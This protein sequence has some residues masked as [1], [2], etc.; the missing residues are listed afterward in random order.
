PARAHVVARGVRRGRG[1][2]RRLLHPRSFRRP[3]LLGLPSPR[4]RRRGPPRRPDRG[5]QGADLHRTEA[6]Y[7][8]PGLDRGEG[9][10]PPGRQTEMKRLGVLLMLFFVGA[11][12]G[13]GG[14]VS[15]DP[16]LGAPESLEFGYVL[17]S[18][19][20]KRSLT[21]RN[22]GAGAATV[23][24]EVTAPFAVEETELSV[25][26]RSTRQLAF[27]FFA[28]EPGPQEGLA[29]LEWQG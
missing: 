23:R 2:G 21:L 20:V 18:S 9:K 8:S 1:T 28:E 16:K 29:T 24:V 11:C 19:E 12:E 15:A 27:S 6:R 17:V 5:G 13:G 3:R 10:L 7:A 4:G 22:S 26:G 14:T 25:P